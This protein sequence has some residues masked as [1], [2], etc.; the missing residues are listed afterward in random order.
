MALQRLAYNA[1]IA[2][3]PISQLF[4]SKG[5]HIFAEGRRKLVHR[6][7]WLR[8]L[9]ASRTTRA[10]A[11]PARGVADLVGTGTAG[12]SPG[13]VSGGRSGKPWPG[14]ASLPDRWKPC[15]PRSMRPS[16]RSGAEGQALYDRWFGARFV[17]AY[18]PECY[19]HRRGPPAPSYRCAGNPLT[20]A[21]RRLCRWSRHW[22]VRNSDRL[23]VQ[24][25]FQYARGNQ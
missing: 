19:V 14:H 25:K 6:R 3:L 24:W 17:A 21:P 1:I 13:D 9:S 4:M 18:C 23:D 5:K 15:S 10:E 7:S 20:P 16:T 12:L 8:R 22:S 11:C 2:V